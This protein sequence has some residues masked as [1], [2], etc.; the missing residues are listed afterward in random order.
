[1]SL[2]L[3]IGAAV[4]SGFST[5]CA[6]TAISNFADNHFEA[7][8]NSLAERKKAIRKKKA[9]STITTALVGTGIGAATGV[10]FS[11]IG[12]MIDSNSSTDSDSTGTDDTSESETDVDVSVDDTTSNDTDSTDSESGDYMIIHF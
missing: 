9:F 4:V 7:K 5:T 10:A 1:M 2:L 12:D 3:E 11:K 8:D 6:S